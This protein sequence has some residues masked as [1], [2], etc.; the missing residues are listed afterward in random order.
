MSRRILIAGN[1]KMNLGPRASRDL[2]KGIQD[3]MEGRKTEA[4]LLVAPPFVSLPAVAE[5]LTASG[6]GVAGQNL[7]EA[8]EGAF[9]GEISAPLLREAGAD[10]VIL[11]HSE[12]RQYFHESDVGVA[13]K[14]AAA[15]DSGL[16]P[17]LCV[18]ET[19]EER[20]SGRTLEIV[21]GQTE[22]VLQGMPED[23]LSKVVLAY[24][25]VWAIG[26]GL[27][28]TPDQAQEVHRAM[29][30]RICSKHGD[31]IASGMRIL[32][33]GSV[34]P[35]NVRELLALEDVDGALVGGAS[36]EAESFLALIPPFSVS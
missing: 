33:G 23:R 21:L 12:R 26:T 7:H 27:T 20:E 10:W 6:I 30:E 17:I 34:K 36:L 24:E 5:L 32:Y 9:T 22:G 29:R 18:G 25:P 35:D 11:G 14:A 4:D 16:L 3:G 15:F 19:R 1:W 8:P 13:R 2:V 31:S 28:A